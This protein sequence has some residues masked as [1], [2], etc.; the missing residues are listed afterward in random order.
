MKHLTVGVFHDDTICRE[1]GKKGTETDITILN[2]KMDETVLTFMAPTEDK[3]SA[4]SQIVSV[5]DAAIVMFSGMTREVGETVVLLD[6]VGVSKGITVTSPY[7]TREQIATITKDTSLKSFIVEENDAV[8][9]L[10]AL[11]GAIPERDTT[12]ST[13][14]V[15]DHSFSVK[16]VGEVILGFVRKGIVRKYDKLT[17]MPAGKEVIVRSIQMQDEDYEEAPAGSRV[18]LAM[19]G[20][21]VEEMKRGSTLSASD[22]IKTATSLNLSFKKSPF[23]SGEV[24]EGAFH[25]TVGMQTIPIT[26]TG[27]TQT[28]ITLQSEKPLA[29]APREAFILLD[30]NAKK[31]RIIGT[32]SVEH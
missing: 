18:G 27:T 14:V 2:R 21:T 31:M 15:V 7:V 17:L 5:I 22:T 13:I 25:V 1:L 19:K 28:S 8:K 32:G 26:I 12:S 9:M 30:L 4:K 29:Y 24:K 16:G 23:Y 6:S 20:A 10:E 11:R 3:L